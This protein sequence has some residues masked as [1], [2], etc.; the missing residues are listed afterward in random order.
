MKNDVIGLFRTI[1]RKRMFQKKVS[2]KIINDNSKKNCECYLLNKEH[3]N[4]DRSLISNYDTSQSLIS[5]LSP[6]CKSSIEC[7]RPNYS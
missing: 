4:Q 5:S 3:N 6:K 2:I 1:D 7:N